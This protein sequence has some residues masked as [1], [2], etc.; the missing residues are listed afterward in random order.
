MGCEATRAWYCSSSKH[1]EEDGNQLS[2]QSRVYGMKCN[3]LR[4]ML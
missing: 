4:L 2:S 3:V 1:K